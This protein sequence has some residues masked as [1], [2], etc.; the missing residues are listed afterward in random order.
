MKEVRKSAHQDSQ[1]KGAT[2]GADQGEE[3]VPNVAGQALGHLDSEAMSS[4]SSSTGNAKTPRRHERLGD[5]S[6]RD[7][8][9]SMRSSANFRRQ[10]PN[11]H[12][13]QQ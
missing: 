11:I 1:T 10:V 9:S 8:I 7:C 12:T 13:M 4:V 5:C 2:S 6:D 3:G